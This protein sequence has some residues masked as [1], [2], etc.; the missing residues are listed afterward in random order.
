MRGLSLRG[1]CAPIAWRSSSARL[2]SRSARAPRSLTRNPSQQGPFGGGLSG[3]AGSGL[4]FCMVSWSHAVAAC[5][6]SLCPALT[7]RDVVATLRAMASNKTPDDATGD[8][9]ILARVH[10]FLA[11]LL[12]FLGFGH[13]PDPTVAG[14]LDELAQWLDGASKIRRDPQGATARIWWEA[15]KLVNSSIKP[16]QSEALALAAGQFADAAASEFGKR[17]L[18][19][20]DDDHDT[21]STADFD[22]MR[23][24]LDQADRY[25]QEICDALDGREGERAFL[26][27]RIIDGLRVEN[28]ALLK[29][30]Q[31]HAS[32]IETVRIDIAAMKVALADGADSIGKL[33]SLNSELEK[34]RDELKRVLASAIVP[35]PKPERVAAGQLWAYVD[36]VARVQQF[37]EDAPLVSIDSR[38]I[39]SDKM[40]MDPNWHYIRS[41]RV[42]P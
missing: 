26:H 18:P 16:D 8:G 27:P 6:V 37:D 7:S 9:V 42:Q 19:V 4:S 24:E 31:H 29:A 12:A 34:E 17:F 22:T 33:L 10:V 13:I 5:P 36:H 35:Q 38:R 2:A 40:L 30:N 28:A 41:E 32:E 23:E 21:L 11:A 1:S 20:A 14:M 15:F 3:S 25:R 39:P